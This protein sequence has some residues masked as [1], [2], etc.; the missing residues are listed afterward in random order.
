M[1][2]I[3][4]NVHTTLLHT[5]TSSGKQRAL[6]ERHHASLQ[7]ATSKTDAVPT[8]GRVKGW[9]WGVGSSGS[10]AEGELRVSVLSIYT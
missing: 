7:L 2:S 10:R 4:Y 5:V 6:H 8:W 3:F 9:G 1:F